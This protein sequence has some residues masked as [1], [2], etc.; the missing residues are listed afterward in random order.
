MRDA[1]ARVYGPSYEFLDEGLVRQLHEAGV[2]VVPWTVN[3]PDHWERLL[4]WGVDGLT[5]D[6]PNRLAAFLRTK[7]VAY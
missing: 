3:E 5:T 7:G 4:A 2:R 1:G 6:F